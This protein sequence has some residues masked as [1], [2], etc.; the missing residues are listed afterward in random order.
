M[1]KHPKNVETALL[2]SRLLH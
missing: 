2:K 1:N